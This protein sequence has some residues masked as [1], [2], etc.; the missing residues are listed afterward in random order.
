MTASVGLAFVA[1]LLSL[2]SPC[3][4]PI[5]PLVVAAAAAE[6]RLG[7]VA[8]AAGVALSF[9]ALGLFVATVGF[10]IGLDER[11]FRSAAAVVMIAAGGLLVLPAAQRR[12]ALATA[13][14]SGWAAGRLDGVSRAGPAGQF[15][16]GLLLG[17]VWTPCVGPTLGAASVL[18]SRGENLVSVATIMGAFGIGAALPLLLI[19]LLSR[20]A[21]LR[22][23]GRLADVGRA[24]RLA[25]GLLLVVTGI[26]VLTGLD[27]AAEAA[28]VE[29][30]PEWLTR[31]T[32]SI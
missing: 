6:H 20:E 10:A 4:L 21:L 30:S 23:R 25:L 7:P 11:I 8:L 26:A 16:V 2:L 28:L 15:G 24:G 3:T 19:G 14:A 18:A 12:F 1:G 31:L 9:V 32:T 13:P 29:A 5:A 27:K 17:A 22:W